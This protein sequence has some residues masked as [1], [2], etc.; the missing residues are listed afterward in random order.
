MR[1]IFII[2]V[3]LLC[4]FAGA[5]TNDTK[6]AP[7]S[8][9][10]N[11]HGDP[12]LRAM[13]AEL[14]RS[15]EKLQLGQLQRPYY[16]EYQVTELKDYLADAT[17]GALR[18][19][20]VNEGRLVRAVVRIGDYKQDS[21]YGE[22]IG[23]SEVLPTDNDVMALR[24]QIW[25]A[26]DKAYKAAL[27][28]LTEKQAALKNVVVETD[29]PDFSQEPPVESVNNLPKIEVDLDK[30]KQITRSNSDQFRQDPDIE[31]SE[32]LL[33]FRILNRYFVNTEGTVTRNGKA[34]YTY[35][36]EASAQAPDGMRLD[37]SHG[38]VVAKPD[39]LPKPEEITA[40]AKKL[41]GTFAA[42]RKAPVVEDDYHGPV[43]FSADAA[44]AIF[45][46]LIVSNILG[47][48][49]ELGNPARV[50]GD[51]ASYYKS[52]VLPD[53]IS[54]VDDPRPNKLEGQTLLGSYD[55]D[56]EGVKAEPVT[57][58]DKGVLVNF[59]TG[60]EPIKDF[61]HSNGHGRT[62]LAGAPRPQISNLIFK[63]SN[64][65]PFE[66]LKKKLIQMCKDQGRP[67]GYYVETTGLRLAPRLL[68]RIYVNDGHQELVR[69]ANFNQLDTRSLRS[70]LIAAGNDEYVYNRSDPV[71]S[72]I[73][74]P[75]L[76]FDELEIQRA[77]RTR[78]KLPTYPAPPLTTAGQ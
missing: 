53:F 68:W 75:S 13:L 64:G 21:Y 47:V 55:V 28:G 5:A 37:R 32:A 12:V 67:Y 9:S 76:L 6:A 56:D 2:F 48:R 60:R 15:Q 49:P 45:E 54:V 3:V 63:A 30:W 14:K 16:I 8:I 41:I 50:R 19:D 57:V 29:L 69:G 31:S 72:T 27:N 43:L 36:F 22:G 52:R 10:S 25:L 26:T 46:R 11:D 4:C 73:V 71:P 35:S 70:D 40:E 66:E 61:P 7:A 20:Q 62:A 58:I 44:T 39:E 17:L 1:R 74:A 51:F 33:H 59:L 77:N 18:N 34:V 42:L 38:Y 23:S 65:V 24:H 78:E